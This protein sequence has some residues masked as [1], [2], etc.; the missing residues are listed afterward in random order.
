MTEFIKKDKNITELIEEKLKKYRDKMISAR[1]HI[2]QYPEVGD[3]EYET[4]NYIENLLKELDIK[5]E[6]LLDTGVLGTLEPESSGYSGKCVA[7]RADID[8]LPICETVDVPF[9]SK[10]E[11]VMHACGHDMHTAAVLC[12]A[13]I[14]SD[15]EVKSILKAPVK[16]IFQPAEE[17]D[18]GAERMINAGCLKSPEVSHVIGC[19]VDPELVSGTIGVKY[20][21]THASSDMFDITVKGVKS[22]GAYPDQGVDAIVAA[23]QIVSGVQSIVSRNIEATE[24]CVIT[25]GKF[26]AGTAG[27]IICDEAKLSGTMRTTSAQSRQTAMKRLEKTA[28]GIAAAMGASAEVN[29][30]PGYISQNNDDY[31]TD[32]LIDTAKTVIDEENIIM[33][34]KPSMGVED[35]AFYSREVPSV[36]FFAGTGFKG[37]T[38]YGI[39]HEKFEADE[40]ALDI[41]VKLEVLTALRLMEK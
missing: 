40:S 14:L 13:M 24:P 34:A 6:R 39:H 25:I 33:K 38:N 35:F 21:Y 2:H 22:H 4:A 12:A 20:G 5:T 32:V 3:K 8:A 27:N 30:R 16:F 23:A 41:M 7:I 36:F 19:H 31:V 17:T 15:P 26:N 1:R 18:G 29:F 9:C 37:R 11:G 28:E 10:N